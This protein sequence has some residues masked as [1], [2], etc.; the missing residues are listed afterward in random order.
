MYMRGV[1]PLATRFVARSRSMS[2]LMRYY[3]DTIEACAP[4]AA[5]LA[6]I[7]AAGFVDVG[8]HVSLGIF[9]EYCARRPIDPT[10]QVG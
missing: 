3:W 7:T 4:P 8:R 6:A 2:K 10:P 9:S 5:I 1:I